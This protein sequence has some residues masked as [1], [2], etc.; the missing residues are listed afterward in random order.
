[1]AP[2]DEVDPQLNYESN[3]AVVLGGGTFVYGRAR[4]A[5][6]L[7]RA[8]DKVGNEGSGKGERSMMLL[9][10]TLKAMRQPFCC[11]H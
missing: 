1:M 9:D 2:G 7:L 11:I 8:G 10:E 6:S 3:A 5:D 4:H